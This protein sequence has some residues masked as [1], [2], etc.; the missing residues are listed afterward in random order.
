MQC[1]SKIFLVQKKGIWTGTNTQN[2]IFL[3][4]FLRFL[5]VFVPVPN[6]K[7]VVLFR[8]STGTKSEK[9][10]IYFEDKVKGFLKRIPL[11]FMNAG[12]E[13]L[14]K[15]KLTNFGHLAKIGKLQVLV[16]P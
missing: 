13:G 8:F 14:A 6:A 10:N 5:G 12:L 2:K 1:S 3:N 9:L 4:I 16:T 11:Y 15:L 7:N